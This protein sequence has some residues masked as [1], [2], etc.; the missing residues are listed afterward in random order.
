M[1]ASRVSKASLHSQTRLI[2]RLQ[3][4]Y[5]DIVPDAIHFAIAHLSM[6]AE[7]TG[8]IVDFQHCLQTI[9][10]HPLKSFAQAI[11]AKDDPNLKPIVVLCEKIKNYQQEGSGLKF[12]LTQELE[13]KNSVH[14]D[15]FSGIYTEQEL[16]QYLLNLRKTINNE[17]AQG[18]IT[19]LLGN[20]ERMITVSYYPKL[21]RWSLVNPYQKSVWQLFSNE[22]KLAKKIIATCFQSANTISPIFTHVYVNKNNIAN[23]KAILQKWQASDDW[24]KMHSVTTQKIAMQDSKGRPWSK[25]LNYDAHTETVKKVLS[26]AFFRNNKKIFAA[27]IAASIFFAALI[28][29]LCFFFPATIPAAM[30]MPL[31]ISTSAYP[32]IGFVSAV[33]ANLLANKSVVKN[34]GDLQSK[35][36]ADHK[37]MQ[38]TDK[39][40][41]EKMQTH[42]PSVKTKKN[43]MHSKSENNLSA[44]A[45]ND[46][47]HSEDTVKLTSS[48]FPPVNAQAE[49]ELSKE[50]PFY[51]HKTI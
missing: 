33:F 38:S 26:K 41:Q 35:V 24:K 44:L 17:N 45:D 28:L 23:G 21:K 49:C 6:Q 8:N 46:K 1:S 42:P 18:K 34:S 11:Q 10:R 13:N 2:K 31:V 7:L 36:T 30:F 20:G 50:K 25:L 5:P 43:M 12:S 40:I 51:L 14:I 9:R 15:S 3:S 4:L 16:Q 22:E 37:N 32:V 39:I 27:F 29:T 47:L 48:V 19:L